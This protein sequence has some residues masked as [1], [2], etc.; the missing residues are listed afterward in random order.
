LRAVGASMVDDDVSNDS[1][2][3]E[4]ENETVYSH[5]SY[6]KYPNSESVHV[7]YRDSKPLCLVS[8]G[9]TYGAMIRTGQV[10]KFLLDESF[11]VVAIREM[12]FH[13][14]KPDYDKDSRENRGFVLLDATKF[15][16]L[17]SC[18]LLPL[19]LSDDKCI[20]ATVRD[21]YTMMDQS[22]AFV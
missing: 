9:D 12:Q 7:D 1:D 13:F 2:F 18:V 22:G 16:V 21:D 5:D 11:D 15:T 6:W 19:K 10:V 4:D 20:Y 3:E 14:W 17:F 8:N